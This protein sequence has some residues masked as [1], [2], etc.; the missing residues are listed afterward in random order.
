MP[1]TRRSSRR[2]RRH[3]ITPAALDRANTSVTR[4][5]EKLGLWTPRLEDV[6]VMLVPLG[7]DA[8]GWFNG[9]I[10]IP[11]VSGPQLLDLFRGHHTRLTDILRHEWAHALADA[12]PRLVG[13]SRRFVTAFGGAYDDPQPVRDYRP[14]HHVTSYAAHSPCEDFAEVFHH[15]LRH[16]GR[17]PLH[18]AAKPV[19]ARKWRFIATLARRLAA[20]RHGW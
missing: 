6:E 9:H 14:S 1:I 8:Y 10:H 5:M 17:I 19:V 13:S 11:C 4:E 18:L 20:G 2:V 15:Y 12:C 7:I 16:K 3:F